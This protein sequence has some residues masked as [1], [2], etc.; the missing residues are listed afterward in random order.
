MGSNVPPN[1]GILMPQ[2]Q[3]HQLV[4]ALFEKADTSAEDAQ[5]MAKLLVL[6]DLRGVHSHGTRKIPDYI[7]MIRQGRVNPQPKVTVISETPT[8][9]VYDGDGGLG[10]FPCYQGTLWAVKK[11]K[12]YGTAAITTRNHR[13]P[14]DHRHNHHH[15]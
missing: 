11:A 13:C 10:H 3:L 7:D 9:R 1:T 15:A 8:T 5:L 4:V 2:E 14:C 6:T 12:E